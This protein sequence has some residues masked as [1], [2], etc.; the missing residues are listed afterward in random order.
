M[1]ALGEKAEILKIFRARPA[2]GKLE[3]SLQ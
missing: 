3:L 2:G 1:K